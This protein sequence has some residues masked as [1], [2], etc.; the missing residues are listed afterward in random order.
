MK[1]LCMAREGYILISFIFYTAGIFYITMLSLSPMA[2]CICSGIILIAYGIVKITGYFSDDLYNLA[3]QYD[4]ACGVFLI[5]VG[6]LTLG[7][8]LRIY[9][10]LAPA[11]GLLILL[12][13]VLKLQTSK[14]AKLFGLK[15]WNRILAFSIAAGI[16]GILIIVEP[17]SEVR[18]THIVNGCGLLVEGAMNHL[19]VKETVKVR[20]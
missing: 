11:L 15:I 7:Y 12:D 20:N 13:S 6:G 16:F 19:I 14:D 2:I 1:K 8:N 17:F 4:L 10:Y 3:F 5:V 9:H 18:V